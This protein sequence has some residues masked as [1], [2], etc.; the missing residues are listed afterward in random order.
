MKYFHIS[1]ISKICQVN[2][3]H[4]L[5]TVGLR[6]CDKEQVGKKENR[7]NTK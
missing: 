6:V 7:R 3:H 2:L 4:L 5:P 1:K